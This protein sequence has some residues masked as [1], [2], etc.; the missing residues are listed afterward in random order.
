MTPEIAVVVP[1]HDRPLRLRWLLNALEEQTLAPDAFEIVVVHDGAG[2]AGAETERLLAEH[3]LRRA[4]RL[5]HL[6]LTPGSGSPGRQRNTGWQS[7]AAELIAFTDDDCRPEP[8]WLERLVEAAGENPGAVV[9]GAT[10]ADPFE[11]ELLKAPH[12]RTIEV[13]PPGPFGQACNIVYPRDAL[14]RTAGFAEQ[15]SAGEDTDLA[16]RVRERG[17]DYVGAPHALVN[18][19]V[20][21][22]SLAATVAA[23]GRWSD[24][25]YVVAEHPRMRERLAGG[26]FWRGSHA[27]LLAAG[28]GIATRR[29]IPALAAALPY[30]YLRGPRSPRPRSLVAG[31]ARL[32]GRV[33]VDTA[34]IVACAR[35]A[36]R[37]RTPFL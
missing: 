35:G 36:V 12:A 3:P 13:E 4:G 17:V 10:R 28:L 9:Q 14:E 29:R 15:L 24:L 37:H 5:R 18:H 1:S 27:A 32:P 8:E 23:A 19:A 33:A 25:A 16:L 2:P 20:T 30:L 22:P 6:H 11:V 26:V 7:S 31:L 21:A 34:E